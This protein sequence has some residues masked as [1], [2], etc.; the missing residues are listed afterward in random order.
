VTATILAPEKFRW[1]R[2]TYSSALGYALLVGGLSVGT[3]L[4]E[5]RQQFDL[6]GVIAA[7]H[8]STF[9]FAPR[10]RL[11]GAWST[12]SGVGGHCCRRPSPSH[13]HRHVLPRPGVAGDPAAPRSQAWAVHRW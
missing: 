12:V 7:M 3:V 5:L 11:L 1:D 9:G 4:G 13:A 10:R 2:L 6:S 8:G